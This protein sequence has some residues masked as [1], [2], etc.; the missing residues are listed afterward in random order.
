M[1]EQIA[2]SLYVGPPSPSATLRSA[3]TSIALLPHQQ[4]AHGVGDRDTAQV[5][6]DAL[7]ARL[8]PD[9]PSVLSPLVD[10]RLKRSLEMLKPRDGRSVSRRLL[11]ELA[12]FGVLATDAMQRPDS[13]GEDVVG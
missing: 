11:P 7:G 8:D 5:D 10:S 4:W 12:P 13:Q 1:L 2:N 3:L 6:A 9:P